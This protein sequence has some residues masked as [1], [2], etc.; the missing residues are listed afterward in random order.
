MSQAG[1]PAGNSCRDWRWT[2][3]GEYWLG[4]LRVRRAKGD[5]PWR[6]HGAISGKTKT[7]LRRMNR[8]PYPGLAPELAARL[9]ARGL[10]VRRESGVGISREGRELVISVLLG[11]RD[12]G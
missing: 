2:G 4:R 3:F 1:S 9:V 7:A 5:R 8:G 11:A 10:A 12:G 6:S